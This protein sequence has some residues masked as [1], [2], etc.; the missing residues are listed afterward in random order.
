MV[1]DCGQ[2]GR[3]FQTG[4]LNGG[5][6]MRAVPD[7]IAERLDGAARVFADHGFDQ[8]RIEQLAEATGIPRATLYYYFAGKEDILAW[9]LRRMLAANA[10]AVARAAEGPGS[11]R[12][13]L[14]AVVLAKL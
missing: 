4:H 10:E 7:G 9:L 3:R 14:E 13:R 11:A 12:E 1:A 8:T 2:S 5:E 6:S